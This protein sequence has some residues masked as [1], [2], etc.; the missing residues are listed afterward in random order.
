MILSCAGLQLN[1]VLLWVSSETEHQPTVSASSACLPL[2]LH[3]L[4]ADRTCGRPTGSGKTYTI[5]TL[6][7]MVSKMLFQAARNQRDRDIDVHVTALEIYNERIR[8]LL[9]D[10]TENQDLDVLDQTKRAT[11]VRGLTE[12][13]VQS[14][15]ELD[16]IAAVASARRTV[17]AHGAAPVRHD[18]QVSGHR[19]QRCNEFTACMQN[20]FHPRSHYPAS[21]STSSL[22]VQGIE[23]AA[24]APAQTADMGVVQVRDTRSNAASSRSH[25]ILRIHFDSRP[26]GA[27]LPGAAPSCSSSVLQNTTP[28]LSAAGYHSGA[29]RSHSLCT[30]PARAGMACSRSGSMQH[31]RGRRS[32]TL[33]PPARTLQP[34]RLRAA[35]CWHAGLPWDRLTEGGCVQPHA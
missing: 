29:G 8:D 16:H 1:P 11:V 26:A 5:E 27:A 18:Q 7:P 21:R 35:C 25:L 3:A 31:A 32:N 20:R 9:Q 15:T 34:C 10:G 17:R 2:M 33:P 30:A 4:L 28:V 13:R 24:Q 23:P 12:A 19:M 14:S 6:L 22:P